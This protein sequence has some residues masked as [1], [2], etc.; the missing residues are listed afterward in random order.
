MLVPMPG[1][2]HPENLVD[3][4]YCGHSDH[5]RLRQASRFT[6][7]EWTGSRI[8]GAADPMLLCFAVAYEDRPESSA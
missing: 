8:D 7:S 4:K 2:A 6:P 3:Q 5:D 1:R